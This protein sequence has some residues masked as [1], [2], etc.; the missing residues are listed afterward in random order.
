MWDCTHCFEA[1]EHC[2]KYIEPTDRIFALHDK[3]IA[4]G[5]GPSY[6]ANHYKSFAASVRAHGWL[7]EGRLAI[8]TEGLTNVR[9]LMKLLP[10]AIKAGMKGKRPL[11]YFLHPKRSG[12]DRIKRIFDKWERSKR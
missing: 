2:P 6:V 9:G 5:A 3:A 10:F 7:D 4:V 8:E 12:A 11:P 1:S